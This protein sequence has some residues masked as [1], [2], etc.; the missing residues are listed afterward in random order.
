MIGETDDNWA[1]C[2]ERVKE[3]EPDNVTIY[4][5]ELP[6]NTLIAREMK[7]MGVTSPVAGWADKTPLGQRG[8]GCAV[9]VGLSNLERQRAGAEPRY[10]P[11]RLSR[12]PVPR[13]RHPGDRAFRR[14][15][16][17]R[18]SIT[19]TSTRSSSIMQTVNAGELPI[20]RAFV[21]TAHQKLIREMCLQMKEGRISARP[22]RA[23]FG[24]DILQEFA[25]PLRNQEA[26]GY[27]T[28]EGDEIRLT[29]RG[30]VAGRHA[31]ARILREGTSR[32]PLHVED[33]E[34][35]S[36][37]TGSGAAGT[38]ERRPNCPLPVDESA[39]ARSAVTPPFVDSTR[40]E[41]SRRTSIA[42][43]PVSGKR[44]VACR[45]PSTSPSQ[46]LPE[47]YRR[48]LVH[49]HHMTVTMES[50]HGCPVDVRDSR[51]PARRQLLQPQNHPLEIGDRNGRAIRHRA[52]RS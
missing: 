38:R 23:K 30:V 4:Q 44:A 43:R 9:S 45:T 20:H 15:G 18:G 52:V 37:P 50:F 24:V 26:A 7:E 48:M 32:H 16:I 6:Y 46:T 31:A 17:S 8:D 47:P 39:T 51:S 29:R 2:V 3:M 49:N 11:L 22:F 40:C 19:R 34:P 21:P 5:M 36:R 1:H 41:P 14:S 33:H 25:A 27:L 28:I 42:H 10:G 35:L 13:K 12:P